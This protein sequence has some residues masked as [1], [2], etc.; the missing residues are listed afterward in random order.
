MSTPPQSAPPSSHPGEALSPTQH[1]VS[2]RDRLIVA[3]DFP[4]APAAL[5]LVARLE[6]RAAWFKVG[7]ELYLATG[8]SIVEILRARGFNVFVDLK[9]HDIPNTV[10]GAVR[11]LASYGASLLTVHASGGL[12]MLVAAAEAA[13]R[14]PN[15]PELLAVT[16]LT[17]MDSQMLAATG[18]PDTPLAQAVRLA[19]LAHSAGVSGMV[20]SPQECPQLR[21]YLGP[22]R[23]LVVPGIRPAGAPSDDQSRIAT[24]FTA[25][26]DGAS[27]LVV[28]RPITKAL[29]PA[30]ATDAI[31]REM[32]HAL[33]T[34]HP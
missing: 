30:A 12:P 31:L 1:L 27:L 33:P 34:Q 13:E 23:L 25:L 8:P 20:C 29:D 6:G 18:V 15:G 2:A 11:S 22:Y 4:T 19:K 5:D 10:A 28:G 7:L 14:I 9:L 26:H 17:S 24:P 3:L 32:E 21:T 16:V